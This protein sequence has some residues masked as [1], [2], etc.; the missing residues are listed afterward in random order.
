MTQDQLKHALFPI[1]DL[2][3]SEVRAIAAE[4][5][6][7]T[8]EKKD[9]QGLCFIGK[10]RLPEFLQQKLSPKEGNVIEI[11]SDLDIFPFFSY[12]FDE[13][14]SNQLAFLSQNHPYS[15]DLGKI[16]GKH[17]GAFYY[18]I[19]QRKGLGI[20]GYDE[21]LLIIGTDTQVN[22]IYVGKGENHP[23]LNRPALF[24]SK[25]ETHWIRTDLELQEGNKK[26]MLVRI[27]Y[28]QALE[29]ACL[30]QTAEGLYIVFE[31]LQR[32]IAPGQFAAWY[33]GEELIGS[34]V[35]N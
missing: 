13:V 5:G 30:Y 2:Q 6:L 24:I 26:I 7:L 21:P 32:G 23:G 12:Q 29:K 20:G 33:D 15:A 3:K 18:T 25:E 17:K 34:G 31:N 11:P 1:G 14:N 19:G 16:V 22:N 10:V 35:I 8:A 9:S 28:R 4:A 27:R